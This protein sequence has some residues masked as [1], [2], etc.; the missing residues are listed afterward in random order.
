[1]TP[2][3]QIYCVRQDGASVGPILCAIGQQT[4]I[5]STRVGARAD[6]IALRLFFPRRIAHHRR[7]GLATAGYC[8]VPR[9]CRY[10][11]QIYDIR[12]ELASGGGRDESN[13]EAAAAAAKA[14]VVVEKKRAFRTIAI[15]RRISCRNI[16]SNGP[17]HCYKIAELENAVNVP[18]VRNFLAAGLCSGKNLFFEC[19]SFSIWTELSIECF[20]NW[21]LFHFVEIINSTMYYCIAVY[22]MINPSLMEEPGVKLTGNGSDRKPRT[23]TPFLPQSYSFGK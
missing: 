5:Y 15:G 11:S 23:L 2:I 18:F 14:A 13:E 4:T 19:G 9:P 8:H 7:F 16:D 3:T 17:F 22:V 21:N 6:G 20:V 12:F 10:F 1:M